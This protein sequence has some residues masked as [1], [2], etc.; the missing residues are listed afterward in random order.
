MAEA[1]E[2]V[3]AAKQGLTRLVV[4]SDVEAELRTG[5][6]SS[7]ASAAMHI[8]KASALLREALPR[9]EAL[10]TPRVKRRL[11]VIGQ[12]QGRLQRSLRKVARRLAREGAG[13]PA[14]QSHV[15]SRLNH[16][17]Q[18]MHQ[19]GRSLRVWDATRSFEQMAETISALDQARQ[20]L[21]ERSRASGR[22][23]SVFE[24]SGLSPSARAVNLRA[25]NANDRGEDYRQRVLEAMR[26][27]APSGY[28]DRL[29]RYYQEIIK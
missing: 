10:H 9:A 29:K 16:A 24:T 20:L 1:E 2:R 27:K 23:T 3:A 5:D 26:S 15:G 12:R 28:L 25:G 18:M 19:G 11:S 22:S 6:L 8:G 17:L 14:L 4:G 21:Q 13:H 7:L